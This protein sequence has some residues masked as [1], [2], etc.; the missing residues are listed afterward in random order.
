VD[1]TIIGGGFCGVITAINLLENRDIPIHIRLV[2]KGYPLA[3]GVAY[4]PHTAGLLLNVP[5]GRMSAFPDKPGHFADWLKASYPGNEQTRDDIASAF[6]TRE[7]YGCYLTH[8]WHEALN[9]R[10]NNA[11]VT[12]YDDFAFDMIED[13]NRFHIYLKN[14]PVLTTDFVLLAT[15]NAEPRRPAGISAHFAAGKYYFNNPWKKECI[16]NLDPG[17]DVLIIGNG[18]TMSD[19]VMGL[20]ENGLKGN[21]YTVSPHGY[22][23]NPWS[24]NKPPYTGF[25]IEEVLHQ[26][27]NLLSIVAAVNKHRKIA[28]SLGRS[29]YSL[30]DSLRPHAQTIWQ[31]FSGMEKRRFIKY[32]RHLWGSFRHRLPGKM[33]GFIRDRYEQG[34]LFTYKGTVSGLIEQEGLVAVSLDCG[35]MIKNIT[36]QRIINCTGPESNPGFSS[37]ELLRNLYKNGL[38]CPDDLEMGIHADPE[39][40]CAITVDGTCKPNLFVIGGNLKGVL[41]ES[42]AVPELRVQAQKLAAHLVE[43]C[44]NRAST[45]PVA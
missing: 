14:H 26:N 20:V 4:H 2:N 44:N 42:T 10:G 9:T 25:K 39:N 35:Q 13:G 8:L 38:I 22:N 7:K 19:T 28:A 1:I 24:E 30:V 33:Y 17:K 31:S 43:K 21:I 6:S 37:N 11:A 32:L 45:A 40:G 23:L 36:V 41:W 15:G 16:A 18:L 34:H 29:A 12:V 5:N 3:K 27:A